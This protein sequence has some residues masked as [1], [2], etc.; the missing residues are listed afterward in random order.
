MTVQDD[1]GPLVPL[2]PTNVNITA[3]S[4]VLTAN[5][6]VIQEGTTL[7]AGTVVGKFIDNNGVEPIGNFSGTATFH[8]SPP[9]PTR[10]P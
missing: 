4:L 9:S 6:V 8:G 10:P 2:A 5:S 1:N 7:P 3:S